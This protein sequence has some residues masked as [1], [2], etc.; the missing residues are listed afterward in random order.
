MRE[1]ANTRKAVQNTEFLMS[2]TFL[3]ALVVPLSRKRHCDNRSVAN[4]NDFD[5]IN[6]PIM[7]KRKL[8]SRD[9][10]PS[11]A[12][13]CPLPGSTYAGHS[14]SPVGSQTIRDSPTASEIFRRIYVH[15]PFEDSVADVEYSDREFLSVE[16]GE[17]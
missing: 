12:A 3:P 16:E 7:S 4:I 11:A 17:F 6:Q 15:G 5:D 13:E 14:R 1:V 2:R 9:I 10:S 8:E